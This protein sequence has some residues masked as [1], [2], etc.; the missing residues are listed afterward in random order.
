MLFL[1]NTMGLLVS[2][3]GL[4]ICLIYRNAIVSYQQTNKIND[5]LFDT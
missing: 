5:K 1:K 2:V 4:A 3:I